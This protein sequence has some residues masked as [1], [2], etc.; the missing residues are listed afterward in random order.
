M[1]PSVNEG[2]GLVVIESWLHHKASLV[3]ERAGVAELIQERR[4]GLLF[5]PDAISQLAEKIETLLQEKELA[6]EIGEKGFI[7]SKKCSLEE[8]VK[9]ETEVITQ[10]VE[11]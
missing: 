11:G 8:G 6:Q 7:T 1:L 4:N 10:L 2:F 5:D 9:S 3:T